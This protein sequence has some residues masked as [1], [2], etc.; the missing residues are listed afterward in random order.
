LTEDTNE[1]SDEQEPTAPQ[2]VQP[3]TVLG[4]FVLLALCFLV[5]VVAYRLYPSGHPLRANPGFID[6]IFANNLVIFAARLILLVSALVLAV[7]AV[8]LIAS[9][10]KWMVARM[11]ITKFGPFV[12]QDVKDLSTE[13]ETWQELWSEADDENEELRERL[14]DSDALI[15]ELYTRLQVA[16]ERLGQQPPPR[17]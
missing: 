2:K 4:W 10:V 1:T 9:M 16:E 13:V 17:A 6:V 3:T 12:V 5:V 7:A 11:W 15:D 8:Y 14:E